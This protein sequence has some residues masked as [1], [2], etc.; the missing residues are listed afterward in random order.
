MLSPKSASYSRPPMSSPK[1]NTQHIQQQHQ[2][3][4]ADTGSFHPILKNGFMRPQIVNNNLNGNATN[5]KVEQQK[6]TSELYYLK[7]NFST[8]SSTSIGSSSSLINSSLSTNQRSLVSTTTAT[9]TTKIAPVNITSTTNISKATQLQN[10][11]LD[12]LLDSKKAREAFFE[13]LRST[14]NQTKNARLN[15]STPTKETPIR[16]NSSEAEKA[17]H[18]VQGISKTPL[19]PNVNN[20]NNNNI[21]PLT[22]NTQK[23]NE[24]ISYPKISKPVNIQASKENSG[25][26]PGSF[27][28]VAKPFDAR[29]NFSNVVRIDLKFKSESIEKIE[30]SD[31]QKNLGFFI[32]N[33]EDN[34][35]CNKHKLNLS[36]NMAANTEQ[37][38][39]TLL[40]ARKNSQE[41]ERAFN[42]DNLKNLFIRK[43]SLNGDAS[44]KK[45]EPDEQTDKNDE[46]SNFK[47]ILFI[48]IIKYIL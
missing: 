33:I 16:I 45:K 21:K 41:I 43:N 47:G 19:N 38:A 24:E 17:T 15:T 3:T 36:P 9:T 10:T 1:L 23:L 35:D 32:S 29:N 13:R 39:N 11:Q 8:T 2:Q 25:G 5:L 6:E 27:S 4:K 7:K 31:G 46:D 26:E 30:T 12:S 48:L 44:L 40:Q 42:R 22:A 14:E 34:E 28:S 18:I 37:T 20:N